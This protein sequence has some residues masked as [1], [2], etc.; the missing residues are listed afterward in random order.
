METYLKSTGNELCS[1]SWVLILD[2]VEQIIQI[3]VFN[4]FFILFKKEQKSFLLI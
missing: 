4:F 1:N 2:F 3:E